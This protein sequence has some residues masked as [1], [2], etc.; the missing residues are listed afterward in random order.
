MSIVQEPSRRTRVL[1]DVHKAGHL[2]ARTIAMSYA[3]EEDA[4]AM[5]GTAQYQRLGDVVGV[6]A[7]RPAD[8]APES[9]ESAEV[10]WVVSAEMIAARNTFRGELA[11][12]LQRHRGKWVA[13]CGA[14]RLGF[15]DTEA[16]L[17]RKYNPDAS[18]SDRFLTAIVAPR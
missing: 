14:K 9:R 5:E 17:Y 7:A 15:A 10:N 8:S 2:G 1:A 3:K 12:L 4:A 11:K 16:E 18:I 13:Y 6:P